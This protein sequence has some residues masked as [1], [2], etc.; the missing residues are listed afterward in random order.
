MTKHRNYLY[1]QDRA[2]YEDLPDF[3]RTQPLSVK[4]VENGIVLPALFSAELPWGKG[5]VLDE[6]GNFVEESRLDDAFGG[7]YV[8]DRGALETS[9][10][11]VICISI[12]PRHWGHFLIDVMSKLWYVLRADPSLKIAYCGLDWE[13]SDGLDGVFAEAMELAGIGPERLLYV[14]RP[15]RFRRIYLPDRALG[16]TQPWDPV[17]REVTARMIA[18]AAAKAAEKGFPYYDKVYFSREN[19]REAKKKEV[20]E[21]E[22]AGLFEK[23]GYK[24]ICPETLSAAEQIFIFNRCRDFVSLSG[25]LSHNSVFAGEGTRVVILNRT[26]APNPPQLRINQLTGLEYTY[27]DVFDR[28]ELGKRSGYAGADN[29][30]VHVLSVN[31]NL[32]AYAADHGLTVEESRLW[33]KTV[34][35]AFAR[36]EFYRLSARQALSAVKQGLK[37]RTGKRNRK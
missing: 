20:G 31:D 8:Y 28:S 18:G 4:I 33:K 2:Q 17:Y 9:G 3:R 26:H 30:I 22:I 21:H 24:V 11:E 27:V 10:E 12:I 6:K 29:R 15:V 7:P 16:F 34:K 1:P 32:W 13:A 14:R 23:N 37:Y 35:K 19:F 5:G 36:A 25:T